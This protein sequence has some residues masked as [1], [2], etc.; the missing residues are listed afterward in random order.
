[1]A[2]L[3]SAVPNIPASALPAHYQADR[4]PLED[5][6]RQHYRLAIERSRAVRGARGR[7]SSSVGIPLNTEYS[8]QFTSSPTLHSSPLFIPVG[9]TQKEP[10][11]MVIGPGDGKL[12]KV[13]RQYWEPAKG[14]LPRTRVLVWKRL[15][16]AKENRSIAQH[17]QLKKQAKLLKEKAHAMF[18]AQKEQLEMMQ[19]GSTTAATATVGETP[20]VLSLGS[21]AFQAGD[22]AAAVVFAGKMLTPRA[23]I[24]KSGGPGKWRVTD[25]SKQ[26]N[27]ATVEAVPADSAVVTSLQPMCIQVTPIPHAE[28]PSAPP[29]GDSDSSVA[30]SV[31][32]PPIAEPTEG[33]LTGRQNASSNDLPDIIGNAGAPSIAPSSDSSAR[34]AQQPSDL[35][36]SPAAEMVGSEVYDGPRPDQQ[37]KKDDARARQPLAGALSISVVKPVQFVN[38]DVVGESEAGA[39]GG[40]QLLPPPDTKPANVTS[41]TGSGGG[42]LTD[43]EHAATTTVPS[44]DTSS[45]VA[46]ATASSSSANTEGVEG[47]SQIGDG[48]QAAAGDSSSSKLAEGSDGETNQQHQGVQLLT[49][50]E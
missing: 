14:G 9:P 5:Q 24:D 41:G 18:V 2:P 17:A 39:L 47:M 3:A 22:A 33:T 37:E 48:S 50:A 10:A 27:P 1:M 28:G 8:D 30:L 11:N 38:G 23:Q 49:P 46:G 26:Q 7:A 6:T 16:E 20:S 42:T 43:T 36:P 13:E 31:P 40:S 4:Q 25:F 45:V 15:D 32:P 19:R 21:G 29:A 12:L 35:E 34:G 44:V